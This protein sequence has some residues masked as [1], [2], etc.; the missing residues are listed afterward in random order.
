MTGACV[1]SMAGWVA[2]C[3]QLDKHVPAIRYDQCSLS[4]TGNNTARNAGTNFTLVATENRRTFRNTPRSQLCRAQMWTSRLVSSRRIRFVSHKTNIGRQEG[5][6]L[7]S[8]TMSA[9]QT[10]FL[11]Q[12]C[13]HLPVFSD[14]L[15]CLTHFH[16]RLNVIAVLLGPESRVWG[17]LSPCPPLCSRVCQ[18][19]S[20]LEDLTRLN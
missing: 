6:I 5:D 7:A 18:Y 14:A 20:V 10:F 3:G 11:Q 15:V 2:E 12:P 13:T 4:S 19:D 1:V 17:Q 16:T 8:T 9:P